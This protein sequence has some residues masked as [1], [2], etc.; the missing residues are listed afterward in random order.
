MMN[1]QR[2]EPFKKEIPST[3]DGPAT[4][5]DN[6]IITILP[7]Y[8]GDDDVI[9]T[10]PNF[11]YKPTG[12]TL[13]WYK[14]PLRD[15]YMNQD[16]SFDAFLDILKHAQDS[17]LINRDY[18]NEQIKLLDQEIAKKEKELEKLKQKRMRFIQANKRAGKIT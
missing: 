6:E 9:C 10:L 18:N 5:F 7:Y 3:I 8:W 16:L 17:I 4:L 11:V 2:L 12:F 13:S 15:S 1:H 14:Y